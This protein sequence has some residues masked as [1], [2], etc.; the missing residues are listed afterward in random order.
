MR[1]PA[2]EHASAQ[3]KLNSRNGSYAARMR[4]ATLKERRLEVG[5]NLGQTKTSRKIRQRKRKEEKGSICSSERNEGGGGCVPPII[6][7]AGFHSRCVANAIM[8]VRWALCKGERRGEEGRREGGEVSVP[9]TWAKKERT[10]ESINFAH[11]AYVLSRRA[12]TKRCRP[13]DA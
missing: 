13:R 3:S 4:Q 10:R 7:E 9:F 11:P 5:G 8:A 12:P 6:S 1:T 2:G